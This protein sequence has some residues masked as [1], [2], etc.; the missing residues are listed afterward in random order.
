MVEELSTLALSRCKYVTG[1]PT[2]PPEYAKAMGP[3]DAIA[4]KRRVERILT[5]FDS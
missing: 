5:E 3:K 2:G 4:V 1:P